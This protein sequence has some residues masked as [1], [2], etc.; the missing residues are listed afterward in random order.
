MDCQTERIR[1]LD[2]GGHISTPLNLTYTVF[3]DALKIHFPQSVAYQTLS[4]LDVVR[5]SLAP[6]FSF[7]TLLFLFHQFIFRAVS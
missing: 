3:R 1:S 5:I 6:S 4:S 2:K 7:P